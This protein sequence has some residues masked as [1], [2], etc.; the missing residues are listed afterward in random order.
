MTTL[1]KTIA[2]TA[3]GQV[4][5][6]K[7][8]RDLCL[9][10]TGNPEYVRGVAEVLIDTHL[11]LDMDDKEALIEWLADEDADHGYMKVE[12]VEV[13]GYHYDFDYTG[14]NRTVK[15]VVL[16]EGSTEVARLTPNSATKLLPV[17]AEWVANGRIV[18]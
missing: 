4:P 7:A 3:I 10:A 11:G 1:T 9:G 13:D 12:H 17:L 14:G 6:F 8:A 2:F 18:Q 5:A 15:N 16:C